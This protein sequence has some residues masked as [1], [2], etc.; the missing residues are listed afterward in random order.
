MFYPTERLRL[1]T[2]VYFAVVIY[3]LEDITRLVQFPAKGFILCYPQFIIVGNWIALPI[4]ILYNL[5]QVKHFSFR[6]KLGG[7]SGFLRETFG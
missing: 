1:I 3:L 2:D 4:V 6:N 5:L 7:F